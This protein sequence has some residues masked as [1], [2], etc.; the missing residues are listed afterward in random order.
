M[1]I[2]MPLPFRWPRSRRRQLN[3]PHSRSSNRLKQGTARPPP[4]PQ[5]DRSLPAGSGIR[6]FP[7][8]PCRVAGNPQCRPAP[9]SMISSLPS[10][11]NASSSR[12]LSVVSV[13]T[14]QGLGLKSVSAARAIACVSIYS[15]MCVRACGANASGG[16]RRPRQYFYGRRRGREPGLSYRIL[17]LHSSQYFSDFGLELKFEKRP[18]R[19]Q[20][21]AIPPST[22]R[23]TP[24][25]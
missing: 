8:S 7:S 19:G 24:V 23:S 21:C 4:F 2:L 14:G 16:S 22:A 9:G 25:I 3:P 17:Q 10:I 5:D 15:R 18:R 6:T 13:S 11:L 12:L 1:L 20:T